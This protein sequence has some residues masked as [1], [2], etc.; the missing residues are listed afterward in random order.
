[1]INCATP[2]PKSLHPI[3][4]DILQKLTFAPK[5]KFSEIMEE[6]YSSDLLTYH[7]KELLTRK[8][9]QKEDGF[10]FLT[11]KGRVYVQEFESLSMNFR[12]GPRVLVLCV[13][14]KEGKYLVT[15]R[16]KAPFFGYRSFPAG[17]VIF[18]EKL[19]DAARRVCNEEVG[20]CGEPNL[21]GLVHEYNRSERGDITRD[22]YLYV[23]N[24]ENV[25][26]ELKAETEEGKNQWMNE[27]EI[28]NC[29]KFFFSDY[30]LALAWAKEPSKDLQFWE[31]D[32][33]EVP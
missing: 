11:E 31:G 33:P 12:K 18:G 23:F 10:Y 27:K 2:D 28:A 21:L 30:E 3:R 17:R 1:M 14:E 25:S 20:L 9:V 32:A 7:L 15:E 13:M 22:A 6:R 26:G 29:A 5:L 24:I 4:K 16:K 19:A 8:L